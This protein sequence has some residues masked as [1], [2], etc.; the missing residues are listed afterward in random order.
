MRHSNFVHLHLHTSYSLLDSSLRL[1]ELFKKAEQYKM[2]AIALTDHG[3]LFGA[4][5]FYNGAKKHGLKPLIGCEVYVAPESRLEKTTNHN[6]RDASYHLILLVKNETGYRNLL[7]L[8]TLGY[9]EGFYYKPRIDKE[10]LS[11][12]SEGLIALSSCARGEVAYNINKENIPRAVKMAAQYK[13]IMGKDNFYLELQYH[14]QEY[15][16]KINKDLVE[17]A[18][19]LSLPLVATNNC[20]YLEPKDA[21]AHEI[22]ICLQTGKTISDSYRMQYPGGEYYFK[23]PEE[24]AKIFGH[25]SGAV[26]NTIKI[27]E[28]CNLDIEFGRSHLPEYPVPET[29]T[30]HSYLEEQARAGLKARM[31][32]M[33]RCGTVFDS[34]AY[35]S[36]LELE[37]Q[38][39]HRMGYP[40]YFLIVWDFI[41]YARDK[42]IPVG[43]GR[44]SAA[45]SLVAYALKITDLD[46]IQYGLLFERFLNPERV[47]MPDIDIDFCMDGRDEVIRYVTEKYGGNKNVSQIITFG[48]MNAKGVI[49]D[50]GRVLDMPYGEVDKIAKL[51]PNRLGI[52]LKD[53]FKAEPKFE[54]LRK[55]SE[56]NQE[57]LDIAVSLEGLPR[58]CSTH[59]AGVV[60]SPKPL[61]EFLPLYKG[62]NDEIVTQFEMSD[63]E[64]LGLLKMDFLGLRTLTVIYNALKIIKASRG[65]GLDMDVI[66]TDDAET[67]KLLGD[68]RTL[69]G[70]Q[71]ESSGMRDLLKKMKP[72]RFEDIIALL[73]LYRPGPLESGMVDDYVKRKHGTME[74]KYE[75][76]QLKDILKETHGVILYQ[77]QVMKIASAL[78]GFSLGDADLLRRAM[79]KKK[80]EEMAQQ[81]EKFIEGSK[82]N[83]IPLPKA[84][85]IFDLMEKFAGYGF[86][87]SHSA[88]YAKVSY[89]TAY[90]KCHYPLEFFG[91][92]ITSEMGNADKVLR[93]INDCR[94][95]GIKLLPPDVNVSQKD[96]TITGNQLVFGLGA[97]KN[98]GSAAIE[99]I[100]EIREKLGRFSSLKEFCEHVDLRVGNKRV[101]ESLIKSGAFDSFGESRSAMMHGLPLAMEAGQARQRD[102]QLGQ[103]SMFDT[104]E[105][106]I[107]EETAAK[108]SEWSDHERL[109]Y[110]KEAIGFYISGHPL[111]RYSKDLAWFTDSTTVTVA[112]ENNDKLVS[113]GGIPVKIMTKTTAKGEKMAIVTLEDLF[114]TVEVILWPE[115]YASILPILADDN[116]ILVKGTV[117]ADGNLPKI[118]AREVLPL[119]EVKK[120]WKGKVHIQFRTPGLERETLQTVKQILL[121][122]KGDN[123]LLL[124]FIFPDEKTK[125]RTIAS[126][127]KIQPSD[128]VIEQIESLL[129]EGAIRFE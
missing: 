93:Y 36:R 75:L 25:I 29:F 114:G 127:I 32:N 106:P 57:L 14:K 116:P 128:G 76:P 120:Y 20:H 82:K 56:K 62:S 7:Q 24:M 65:I 71:L 35:E 53:A 27:A 121:S 49:R 44:G 77:E 6:L 40:G 124:H 119:A 38:V 91:A 43:P 102:I 17:I 126:G 95:M 13:E 73:A 50:V 123:D 42:D 3:N 11:Q 69:G 45:G 33:S 129:G 52:T 9:M 125:T 37:L 100:L 74:E 99:S 10:L 111:I 2:P 84:E 101:I 26:E 21:R 16:E 31:E 59:A 41:R 34:P 78:G 46:P 60:I 87:K 30:L 90:L 48:S 55:S 68:A 19:S 8:V 12:H 63:I 61:T 96:F 105:E 88:A 98:V 79:G 23:S 94:S 97:I 92:L 83:H 108:V 81:R 54:E 67:Y 103:F 18:K 39:I 109:K 117:D 70:F 51:V 122:Y 28:H 110:E 1:E 4:I 80:P 89:Q 22:L 72:D 104:F 47:S 118:I 112:D 58:H 15:Q 115:L 85:K 5:E 64:K 113:L 107:P 66:P 86:N